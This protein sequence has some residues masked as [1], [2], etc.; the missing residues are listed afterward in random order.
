LDGFGTWRRPATSVGSSRRSSGSWGAHEHAGGCARRAHT[1]QSPGRP[2]RV[3]PV[4][5]RA[6]HPARGSAVLVEDVPGVRSDLGARYSA[7]A[8][9]EPAAREVVRDVL[10]DGSRL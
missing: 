10:G 7:P 9:G 3:P 4:L 6:A 2:A 5:L 1:G 8:T